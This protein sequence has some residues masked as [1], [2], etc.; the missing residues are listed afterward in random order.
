MVRHLYKLTDKVTEK[1]NDL[2]FET[3][4]REIIAKDFDFI[5]KAYGFNVDLERGHVS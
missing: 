5:V 4:T 2:E 1:F 3:V